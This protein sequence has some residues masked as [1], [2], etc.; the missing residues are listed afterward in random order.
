MHEDDCDAH[1]SRSR[2]RRRVRGRQGLG[3]E[4]V[5]RAGAASVDPPA[6]Q[7]HQVTM[8]SV[9][10][11]Q[12]HAARLRLHER[13]HRDHATREVVAVRDE[14]LSVEVVGRG[15]RAP[16]RGRRARGTETRPDHD[17][18]DEQNQKPPAPRRTHFPH[19]P[20]RGLDP[21][22]AGTGAASTCVLAR[23]PDA[24]I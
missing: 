7:S 23:G 21:S 12:L 11:P 15:A 9:R 14:E 19:R 16:G 2:R 13:L 3:R 5:T 6:A 17:H 10:R 1:G 8:R 24:P 18:R 20:V 22:V 4:A